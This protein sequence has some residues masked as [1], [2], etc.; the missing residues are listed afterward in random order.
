MTRTR[1]RRPAVNGAPPGI[2][3]T[4]KKLDHQDSIPADRQDAPVAR[5]VGL[6]PS[7]GRTLWAWVVGRCPFCAGSHMHRGG[8]R[9]GLRRA[10]CGKGEYRVTAGRR[11]SR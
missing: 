5:A 4:A 11:W 1:E 8:S 2:A 10:G 3:A 7:G 9:G 6:V